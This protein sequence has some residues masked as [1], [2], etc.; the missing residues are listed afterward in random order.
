MDFKEDKLKLATFG[1]VTY[2]EFMARQ[3]SLE[4]DENPLTTIGSV[5]ASR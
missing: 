5:P 3:E 1:V 4:V 2:E